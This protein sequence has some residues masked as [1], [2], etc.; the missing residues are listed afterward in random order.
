MT[1]FRSQHYLIN[2]GSL[3]RVVFEVNCIRNEGAIQHN[4]YEHFVAEWP[5][6]C[7]DLSIG[8]HQ[9]VVL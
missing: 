2:S 4:T 3:H 5:A 9:A 6:T 8:R 1:R 7:F